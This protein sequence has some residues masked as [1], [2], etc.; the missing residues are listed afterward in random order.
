MKKVLIVDDEI[1]VATVFE[2]ALKGAG[3]EVKMAS[4]A[5]SGLSA[6]KGDSFD[7]VLMDQMMPDM[8]GNEALKTLKSDPTTSSVPVAMLTNFGH[9][10]MVK[11]ALNSQAADYILKY[12]ISNDGLVERVKS[13]IGPPDSAGGGVAA[14]MPQ[15]TG[16]A[17]AAAPQP[18]SAPADG[19]VPQPPNVPTESSPTPAPV[20]PTTG[21]AGGDSAKTQ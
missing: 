6:A 5:K 9:D 11:E 21:E 16:G 20:Q 19:S 17:P 7:L 1:A 12:Q 13:I 2:S 3:Y 4:D 15:Q 10:T 18:T 8:S 14:E